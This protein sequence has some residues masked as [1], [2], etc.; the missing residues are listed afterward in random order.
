MLSESTRMP[1]TG[2]RVRVKGRVQEVAVLGGRP[3]GLHLAA[4]APAR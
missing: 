3:L 4:P 1:A 2:E